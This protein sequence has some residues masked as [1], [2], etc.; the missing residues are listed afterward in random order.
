MAADEDNRG[1]SL[2]DF[3]CEFPIKMMGR[4]HPGFHEAARTIIARHAPD[5]KDDAFRSA[6]SRNARFVSLTVTILATS[7]AQLDT[8]YEEL[9]AHDE[10]LVAL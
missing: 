4:D 9:S 8:I 1:E 7:Q 5:V 6:L 10:I 2:L 3:P